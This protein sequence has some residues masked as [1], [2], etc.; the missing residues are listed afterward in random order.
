ML[1]EY[2]YKQYLFSSELEMQINIV[3]RYPLK[4]CPVTITI[5]IEVETNGLKN[6]SVRLHRVFTYFLRT[7]RS[8]VILSKFG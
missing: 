7:H 6:F 4:M 8:A 2:M 1:R 5:Y 3:Y